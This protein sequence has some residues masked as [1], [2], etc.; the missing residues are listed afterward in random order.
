M[1]TLKGFSRKETTEKF[2]A[3]IFVV[4]VKLAWGNELYYD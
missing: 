2:E 3:W 4:K 1:E